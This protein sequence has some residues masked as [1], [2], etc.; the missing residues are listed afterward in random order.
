MRLR[1][2]VC[3][4]FKEKIQVLFSH[5]FRAQGEQVNVVMN[6]IPNWKGCEYESITKTLLERE[7]QE[8]KMCF[9]VSGPHRD[10]VAFSL[11]GHSFKETASTGQIRLLSL[12]IR[13]VQA[14]YYHA[15]TGR[16]MVYL[17]DD[18]LLELDATKRALFLQ[19]IPKATQHFFTFL[20]NETL[21]DTFF[22]KASVYAVEHG[23]ITA[24]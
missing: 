22:S 19:S 2:E 20:P 24:R 5:I 12:L 17:F 8:K 3:A 18:V 11:S 23:T 7:E 9:C 14:E 6:Y 15:R 10:R 4:F 21:P 13:A 16:H 1:E